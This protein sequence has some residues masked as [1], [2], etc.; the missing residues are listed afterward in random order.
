MYLSS[1]HEGNVSHK[2]SIYE[3]LDY[4]HLMHKYIIGFSVTDALLL[5]RSIS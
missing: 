2:K 1:V 5:K 4:T 3:G